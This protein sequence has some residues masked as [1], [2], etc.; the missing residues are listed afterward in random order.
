MKLYKVKHYQD[1]EIL[2]LTEAQ[3]LNEINRD[4]SNDFTP[5]NSLDL[6]TEDDIKD[7]LHLTEYILIGRSI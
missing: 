1:A 5:Y 6:T 4:R 3:L 2:T 7:A